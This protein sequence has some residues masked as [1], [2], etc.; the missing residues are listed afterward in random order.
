MFVLVFGVLVNL[1]S[2]FLFDVSSSLRIVNLE[3]KK[4]L[5]LTAL[6]FTLTLYVSWLV[7]CDAFRRFLNLKS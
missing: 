6:V 1:L 2:A 5:T 7:L 3:R 4:N